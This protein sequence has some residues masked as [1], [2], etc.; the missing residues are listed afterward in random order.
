[1]NSSGHRSGLIYHD[2]TN[3]EGWIDSWFILMH[4]AVLLITQGCIGDSEQDL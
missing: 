2:D 4:K 3:Y 1:M